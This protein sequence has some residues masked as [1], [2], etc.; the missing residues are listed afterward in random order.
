M[1]ISK[2]VSGGLVRTTLA[3][4]GGMSLLFFSYF[5]CN[6]EPLAEDECCEH[7][8]EE[9]NVVTTLLLLYGLNNNDKT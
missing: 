2:W 9:N 4:G 3:C 5:G 7:L 1:G 6:P 8:I